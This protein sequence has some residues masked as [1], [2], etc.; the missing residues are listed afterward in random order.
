MREIAADEFKGKLA[1][2]TDAFAGIKADLLYDQFVKKSDAVREAVWQ[3]IESGDTPEIAAEG[4]TTT[5]LQERF[6]MNYAAAAFT[7]DWLQRDPVQ[8]KV[9][10]A[11]GIK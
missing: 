9:A 4:Y 3:W 11:R 8:A 6:G 2:R 1:L 5:S 10:I 7:I